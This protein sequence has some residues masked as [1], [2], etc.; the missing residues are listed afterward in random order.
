MSLATR[1]SVNKYRL[2]ESSNTRALELTP[3]KIKHLLML[4][5]FGQQL[6]FK[7]DVFKLTLVRQ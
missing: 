6:A 1:T 2:W 3:N 4:K 5:Q 7:M